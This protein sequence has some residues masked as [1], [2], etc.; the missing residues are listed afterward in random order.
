[1]TAINKARPDLG[2][3]TQGQIDCLVLVSHNLTSKEIGPLLGISLHTVDQRIRRAI[4]ALN[5]E[6]RGDA[7]RI[8]SGRLSSGLFK[9]PDNRLEPLVK[10]LLD[11]VEG[12]VEFPLPVAT[13]RHPANEL[14]VWQR[15]LWIVLIAIGAAFSMGVYL[16]GLASFVRMV[17]GVA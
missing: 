17:N 16:A 9:W 5:V 2:R 14:T 4:R 8:V 11:R 1:M 7:A 6:R 12:V 3:L 13:K 10:P 15:L